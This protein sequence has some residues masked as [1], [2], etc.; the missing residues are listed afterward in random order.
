MTIDGQQSWIRKRIYLNPYDLNAVFETT[1]TQTAIDT[2]VLAQILGTTGLCGFLMADDKLLRGAINLPYD[3]D[4]KHEIGFRV[5]YSG[6]YGSGTATVEW[7]LLYKIGAENAVIATTGATALDTVIGVHTWVGPD[8]DF[9]MR[10]PRGIALAS[11]H[12]ITRD[13]VEA[14][15]LLM[16]SLEQQAETNVTAVE[17]ITIEM[18]YVPHRSTGYGTDSDRPLTAADVV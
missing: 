17:F 11:T 14:G 1:D 3:L 7:I 5:H 15:D 2:S 12:G 13:N 10:S 16:I 4:V 9:K 8:D 6:T 18:D